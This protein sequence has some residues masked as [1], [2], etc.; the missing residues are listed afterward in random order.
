[1]SPLVPST[2]LLVGLAGVTIDEHQKF[3]MKWAVLAVIVMTAFALIIGAIT[4]F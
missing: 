1:L 3:A 4:I 2:H